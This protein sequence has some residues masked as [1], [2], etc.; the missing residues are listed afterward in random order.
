M[1]YDL[2]NGSSLTVPPS[3]TISGTL[4]PSH[5]ARSTRTSPCMIAKSA[6]LPEPSPMPSVPDSHRPSYTTSWCRGHVMGVD[7]EE[8][9]AHAIESESAEEDEKSRV[10]LGLQGYRLL[11]I[12]PGAALV[13]RSAGCGQ[14]GQRLS[15]KRLP[16]SFTPTSHNV[17]LRHGARTSS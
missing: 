3:R 5:P 7:P 16:P 2:A 9:L 4:S 6:T 14:H 1:K 8:Y 17:S 12:V 15:Q 11:R 13:P 10:H